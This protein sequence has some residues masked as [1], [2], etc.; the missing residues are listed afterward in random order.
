MLG[1]IAQAEVNDQVKD[2]DSSSSNQQ[3]FKFP[4]NWKIPMN[5]LQSQFGSSPTSMYPVFGQQNSQHDNRRQKK[6]NSNNNNNNN[7]QEN[8]KFPLLSQL[9]N[10]NNKNHKKQQKNHRNQGITDYSS[11]NTNKKHRSEPQVAASNHNKIYLRPVMRSKSRD[12][13]LLP[14]LPVPRIRQLTP[15][16]EMRPPPVVKPP[17]AHVVVKKLV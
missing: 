8:M 3:Q 7:N 13:K 17:K 14:K 1:G 10:Y 11:W 9:Q 12:E 4:N 6:N 2:L 5:Q 15:S 16:T